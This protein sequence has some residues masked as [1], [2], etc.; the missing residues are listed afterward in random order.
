[1]EEHDTHPRPRD[2]LEQDRLAHIGA[3]QPVG[4]VH[5]EH[6]HP[7][8]RREIAPPLKRRPHQASAT[9]AVIHVFLLGSDGQ[10]VGSGPF[11]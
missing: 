9:V 2:L 10:P 4:A 1:M 8:Q 11:T 5:L 7:T 6:V 3:G